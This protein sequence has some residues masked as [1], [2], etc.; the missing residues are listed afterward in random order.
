[1]IPD[2]RHRCPAPGVPRKD[3]EC[4]DHVRIRPC[5]TTTAVVPSIRPYDARLPTGP[6]RSLHRSAL[7]DPQPDPASSDRSSSA[8]RPVTSDADPVHGVPT[9]TPL[10]P[11]LCLPDGADLPCSPLADDPRA[12]PGLPHAS[13]PARWLSERRPGRPSA[14]PSRDGP[15]RQ[16]CAGRVRAIRRCG[17]EVGRGCAAGLVGGR[18]RGGRCGEGRPRGRPAR[19]SRQRDQRRESTRRPSVPARIS[20]VLI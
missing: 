1:M 6:V 3:P 2:R 20:Q 19:G 10:D 11:L 12:A 13:D 9:R 17:G 16:G 14:Q 5:L 8:A 7:A 4:D 18:D 15:H